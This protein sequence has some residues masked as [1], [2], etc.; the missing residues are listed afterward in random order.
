M[1]ALAAKPEERYQTGE[2]LRTDLAAFLAG[3]P[4]P[5]MGIRWRTSCASCSGNIIARE[6]EERQA[7]MAS[8]S[9]LLDAAATAKTNAITPVAA[10]TAAR[11]DR[12]DTA[13][14]ADGQAR[15]APEASRLSEEGSRMVGALLAGRYHINACA[16]E[17]GMGRVYEA[18]H[19]EIG[20]RVRSRSCTRLLRAPPIWS[21]AS[22]ARRARLAHRA[23]Q[24]GQRDRLRHHARRF[25]VLRDGVHRGESSWACLST[26]RGR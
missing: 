9:A 3:T 4:P 2:E 7:L 5:W 14:W 21:S 23:P 8:A 26:A 12:A 15:S 13:R 11:G 22:G 17:G 1:K 25:A 10:E 24:R 19:I 20:K 16:G 6:R 18:E